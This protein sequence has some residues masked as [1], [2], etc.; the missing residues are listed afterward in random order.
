[1]HE[2]NTF[3]GTEVLDADGFDALTVTNM[4]DGVLALSQVAED[5][6]L[7]NVIL[8]EDQVAALL[9]LLPQVLG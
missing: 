7:H 8:G 4:G 6:K 3:R 9:K 5:G 1:M 2:L